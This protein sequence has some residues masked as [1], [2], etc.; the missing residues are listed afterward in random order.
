MNQIVYQIGAGFILLIVIA[1]GLSWVNPPSIE[2]SPPSLILGPSGSSEITLNTEFPAYPK[3]M[4][5]YAVIP[6]NT[7]EDA[8]EIAKKIRS[9]RGIGTD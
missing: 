1:L 8:V 3:L 5:V 9:N 7:R 6:Q 4:M 2:N